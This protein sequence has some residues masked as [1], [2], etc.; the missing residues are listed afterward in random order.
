MGLI[1]AVCLDASVDIHMHDT[2]FVIA[3]FHLFIA[4]AIC[5][6]IIA[7]LYYVVPLLSGRRVFYRAGVFHL[8]CTVCGT[9]AN[10]WPVQYEVI[11]GGPRRYYD[12]SAWDSFRQFASMNPGITII[13]VLLLL[14][15]VVFGLNLLV[16]LFAGKKE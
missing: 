8:V 13:T 4:A 7:G 3:H 15:Q 12:Y 5:L 14:A 9:I 2:Y 1:S 16:S 10:F 11:P 6:L